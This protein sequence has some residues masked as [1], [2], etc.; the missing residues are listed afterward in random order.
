MCDIASLYNWD[1]YKNPFPTAAYEMYNAQSGVSN[2]RPTSDTNRF[3]G[4]DDQEA[5]MQAVI[6]LSK[7]TAKEEAKNWGHMNSSIGIPSTNK[8]LPEESISEQN[9]TVGIYKHH[10]DSV[11]LPLVLHI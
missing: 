6:E 9:L 4:D 8:N 5:Q 1:S 7:R 3:D 11:F 10:E 2:F